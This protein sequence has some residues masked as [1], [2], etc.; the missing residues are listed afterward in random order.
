MSLLRFDSAGALN[1]SL[2]PDESLGESSPPRPN[3]VSRAQIEA[4]R[5]PLM[6]LQS[7]FRHTSGT[8]IR[9]G[10]DRPE[11]LLID[12]EA[13]REKSY[14]GRIFRV[15]N[16]LHDHLDAIGVTGDPSA[17]LG[18]S[19]LMQACCE[20]YHNE[21]SRAE[22]G[23]KP[24][25][26]FANSTVENDSV[27][28]MLRRL[29]VCD[30]DCQGPESRFAVI[31]VDAIDGYEETSRHVSISLG[32]LAD[33][34]ARS[35]GEER[36]KWMPKL[37]VPVVNEAGLLRDAAIELECSEIFIGNEKMGGPFGIYSAATLLPAAFLGLDCIQFLVG[38]AA[39]NDHFL[40]ADFSE[41]A[42]LQYVAT[43]RLLKVA[44]GKR[45]RLLNIWNP[46]LCGC[47]TWHRHW[48]D[49]VLGRSLRSSTEL[50]G[51]SRW[52]NQLRDDVVVNQLLVESVRTD[53]VEIARRQPAG[54]HDDVMK[55]EPPKKKK[56]TPKPVVPAIPDLL[57]KAIEFSRQSLRHSGHPSTELIL[58]NLETHTLGQL[59]Q[60]WWLAAEIEANW[61]TG[62]CGGG[63]HNTAV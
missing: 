6:R 55:L 10:F 43:Q 49:R 14:L 21:L 31:A 33:R 50:R 59:F 26:Y 38:A 57:S 58:P 7:E 20:P 9:C 61:N 45:E 51:D 3:G 32:L 60:F 24:R 17:L 19:A 40:A 34:L 15:A 4:Q 16:R 42:V 12:Y 54:E 52:A 53:R 36:T 23:S 35:L 62:V 44:C 22:R 41:N 48:T 5:E 56:K 8:G 27:E 13:L 37:V 11:Q 28:G 30:P 2:R 1:E 29:A 18:P 39:M 47:G 46:A 63:V 25:T